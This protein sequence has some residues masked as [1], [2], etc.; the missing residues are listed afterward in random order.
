[1]NSPAPQL[2]RPAPGFFRIPFLVLAMLYQRFSYLAPCSP[3]VGASVTR[4]SRRGGQD[5]FNEPTGP[6]GER[7]RAE[8]RPCKYL[9]RIQG[10]DLLVI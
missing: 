3:Q 10:V 5:A 9:F 7:L 4:R 1:M 2:S 6:S 8:G